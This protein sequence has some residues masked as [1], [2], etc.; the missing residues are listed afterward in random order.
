MDNEIEYKNVKPILHPLSDLTKEI[1]YNGEVF[2]PIDKL[3]HLDM[4]RCDI[5]LFEFINLDIVADHIYSNKLLEFAL[6]LAKWHFDLFNG[7]ESGDAI[8]VNQLQINPYK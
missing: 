7:I 4:L 8:D 3:Y 5:S 2:I 6:I 1:E